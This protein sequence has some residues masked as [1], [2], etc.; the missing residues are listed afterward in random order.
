LREDF[1]K[2]IQQFQGFVKVG[3][4]S[5][6]RLS[7]RYE[8]TN[9]Y[10]KLSEK[11]IFCLCSSQEIAL[12]VERIAQE[13]T[14]EMGKH[15]WQSDI[16]EGTLGGDDDD[17]I[18]YVTTPKTNLFKCPLESCT[19]VMTKDGIESHKLNHE[20]IVRTIAHNDMLKK[21]SISPMSANLNPVP[22]SIFYFIFISI[23]HLYFICLFFSGKLR[24]LTA[25][26]VLT[27]EKS[28]EDVQSCWSTANP[29]PNTLIALKRSNVVS[30]N[31]T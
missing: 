5:R 29:A 30:A 31:V 9:K 13:F 11:N 21:M 8:I 10:E 16:G 12:E 2:F 20:F 24:M 27:V 22:V 23:I 17:Y 15:I 26:Y 3:K 7:V 4:T 25:R 19:K 28:L 6:K 18:V 1:S 14:K